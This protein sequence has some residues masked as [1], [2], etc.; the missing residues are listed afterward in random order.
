MN[1][2]SGARNQM[3][4]YELMIM[5]V[6]VYTQIDVRQI[7]TCVM[8]TCV[9]V[10]TQPSLFLSGEKSWEAIVKIYWAHQ[11]PELGFQV[12][13]FNKKTQNPGREGWSQ[14]HLAKMSTTREWGKVSPPGSYGA[15]KL[16]HSA[17]TV[18]AGQKG[19]RSQLKVLL[20]AR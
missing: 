13:F 8:C 14:E 17:Q 12:F 9:F 3:Y 15:R 6:C 5:R 19:S 1:S 16:R 20:M 18:M 11:N 2:D 10:Y 4:Q 7:Q